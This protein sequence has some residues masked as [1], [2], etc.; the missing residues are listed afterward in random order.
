MTER[1]GSLEQTQVMRTFVVAKN[2][3]PDSQLRWLLRLPIG[4]NGLVLK[5]R[6]TWPRTAKLYCHRNEVWPDGAEVIQEVPVKVYE[7]KG[8]AIDLV[9]DRAR[10]NRAQFV[11]A[12]LPGGREAIFWQTARTN[13]A[14]RPSVRVPGRRAAHMGSW[15][16]VVDSSERYAYKFTG[17]SVTIEH[18]RLT[19]GDYGV[20]L[21]DALLATVE[22]KSLENLA[23]DLVDGNLL[24][25]MAALSS[26]PHA[27]VVVEH[28]WSAL[29]K[30]EHVQGGWLADVLARLAARYPTV[31]IMFCETRP[32]AEDWTY[33]FLGAALA[34]AI[35]TPEDPTAGRTHRVRRSGKPPESPEPA[36]A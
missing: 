6:D 36:S 23:K 12:T 19:A 32:L 15:A 14:A 13:R 34:L 20:F 25:Q 24:H 33:R 31:P 35:D 30:L 27:A 21:N 29:F 17:R 9:L 10:E 26:V 3:D 8:V 2:P 11:F 1:R 22:R 5:T 7:R 28:R 4:P 16:I 18:R